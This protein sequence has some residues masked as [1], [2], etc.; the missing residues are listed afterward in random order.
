[1]ILNR[2]TEACKHFQVSHNIFDIV[3]GTLSARTLIA[4]QNYNRNK[5]AYIEMK[6]SFK[7]VWRVYEEKEPFKK[8]KVD[9]KAKKK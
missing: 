7:T 2:N 1:M 4:Q 9:T 6:P 3:E 8:E 5:K